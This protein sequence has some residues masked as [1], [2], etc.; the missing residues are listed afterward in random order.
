[1]MRTTLDVGANR[2]KLFV[3]MHNAIA[4]S[5]EQLHPIATW[6]IASDATIDATMDRQRTRSA[7]ANVVT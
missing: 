2:Q 3:G 7:S 4:E 6:R 1:V 5:H